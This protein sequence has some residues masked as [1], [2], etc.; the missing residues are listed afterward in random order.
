MQ[1]NLFR[2]QKPDGE[3][4]FSA[5]LYNLHPYNTFNNFPNAEED[6]INIDQPF[7]TFFGCPNACSLF[8]WF[9]DC[10]ELIYSHY[11]IV[12]IRLDSDYLIGKSKTQ[13]VFDRNKIISQIKIN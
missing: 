8:H 3:G 7:D 1:R 2:V 4:C 13:V 10:I 9:N 6:E 11:D 12:Y 5:G